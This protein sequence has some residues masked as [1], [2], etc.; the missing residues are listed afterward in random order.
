[1]RYKTVLCEKFLANG[2]CPYGSRCQFAHG[3]E[4]LRERCDKTKEKKQAK[5]S[6]A[7]AAVREA[8]VSSRATA[9]HEETAAEVPPARAL[10]PRLEL[11]DDAARKV[12]T[13]REVVASHP[14]P[15][16]PASSACSLPPSPSTPP[17]LAPRLAKGPV[18][19]N[20][21]PQDCGA[22]D[23]PTCGVCEL[24]PVLCRSESG[25]APKVGINSLT[26][27]VEVIRVGRQ[28]SH[29]TNSVRRQLSLLF[30]D[31]ERDELAAHPTSS[32]IWQHDHFGLPPTVYT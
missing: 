17:K 24:Q 18:T 23:E 16:S 20:E 32:A 21:S 12:V 30:D 11:R 22:D 13:W 19:E 3:T 5:G 6:R 9:P 8:A 27:K 29:N 14:P 31:D 28:L 26:G 15:P 4:E 25:I 7:R 2:S 1:V 10:P